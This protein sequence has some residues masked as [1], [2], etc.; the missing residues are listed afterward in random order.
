MIKAVT[1]NLLGHT[2]ARK[3]NKHTLRIGSPVGDFKYP[4][5]PSAEEKNAR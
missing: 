5:A 4:T 2:T 3:V 1:I